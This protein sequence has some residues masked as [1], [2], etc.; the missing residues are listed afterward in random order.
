MGD[1]C[2]AVAGPGRVRYAK[3]D[4]T[5]A[6]MDSDDALS[7]DDSTRENGSLAGGAPSGFSIFTSKSLREQRSEIFADVRGRLPDIAADSDSSSCSDDADE[8][9][10]W[11]C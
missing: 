8:Q 9:P 2:E 4:G 11:C 7:D 3:T 6:A 10:V 1:N 5:V